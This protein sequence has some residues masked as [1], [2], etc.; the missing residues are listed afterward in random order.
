MREGGQI[1]WLGHAQVMHN[2]RSALSMR[3]RNTWL[4]HCIEL[5]R[6]GRVSSEGS[7]RAGVPATHELRDSFC[8]SRAH[9][10]RCTVQKTDFA[11]AF[12]WDVRTGS[13]RKPCTNL[14]QCHTTRQHSIAAHEA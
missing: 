10:G 4:W 2:V 1:F 13:V 12:S 3:S 5:G 14:W 6:D 9:A 11:L 8:P 7:A